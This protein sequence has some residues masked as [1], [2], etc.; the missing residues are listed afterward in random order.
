MQH[1]AYAAAQAPA[2]AQAKADRQEPAQPRLRALVVEPDSRTRP[3]ITRRLLEAG[4][5]VTEATETDGALR[6]ARVEA[7]YVLAVVEPLLKR[8]D[9]D[10][11][12]LVSM[13]IRLDPGLQV[14]AYT[15]LARRYPIIQ[16]TTRPGRSYAQRLAEAGAYQAIDKDTEGLRGLMAEVHSVLGTWGGPPV[17]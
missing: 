6:M 14:I 16:D 8:A 10:G 17:R 12:A 2:H 7:P 11:I 5:E 15:D 3:A 1:L 4:L 13:L 9:Q